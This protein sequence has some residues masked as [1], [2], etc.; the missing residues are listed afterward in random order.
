MRFAS[1]GLHYINIFI[2]QDSR[3]GQ[4]IFGMTESTTDS[5]D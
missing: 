4:K 5:D 1:S 2:L 3:A